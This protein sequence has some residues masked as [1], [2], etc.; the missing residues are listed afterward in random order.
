MQRTRFTPYFLP[1]QVVC[2]TNL[3]LTESVPLN[4]FLSRM[5]NL[6]SNP[7]TIGDWMTMTKSKRIPYTSSN[8]PWLLTIVSKDKTNSFSSFLW[9]CL[10]VVIYCYSCF[11]FIFL[12]E[13]E[14]LSI[15]DAA[16]WSSS[17]NVHLKF[18]TRKISCKIKF[19]M[20][21]LLSNVQSIDGHRWSKD[22][23]Y[24]DWKVAQN[25]YF[26]WHT[27]VFLTTTSL[28]WSYLLNVVMGLRGEFENC[29]WPTS[30][31][32]QDC[33]LNLAHLIPSGPIQD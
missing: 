27:I 3:P 22:F 33:H 31:Q 32:C 1:S 8:S 23:R 29:F 6:M 17:L 25:S 18:I 26:E 20:K 12:S 16:S 11:I 7:F 24:W 13:S 19:T 30:G 5:S 21:N 14:A 28:E 10:Y 9:K 15:M 2:M 4:I